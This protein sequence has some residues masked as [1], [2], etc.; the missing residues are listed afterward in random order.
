MEK[1]P[2]HP[3]AML[4]KKLPPDQ[5][6]HKKLTTEQMV[7]LR[8][9]DEVYSSVELLRELADEVKTVSNFFQ[10]LLDFVSQYVWDV[11]LTNDS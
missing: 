7:H 9:M 6:Q 5:L 8:K 1:N 3:K 10:G 4:Y 2:E 11:S